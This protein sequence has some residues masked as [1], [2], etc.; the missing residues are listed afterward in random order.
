MMTCSVQAGSDI[1]SGGICERNGGQLA[2][3]AGWLSGW[4][5]RLAYLPAGVPLPKLHFEKC[6]RYRRSILPFIRLPAGMWRHFGWSDTFGY[7]LIQE[8]SD[9]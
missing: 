5:Q 8:A 2:R 3:S 1:L 4:L 7:R 9:D 6:L